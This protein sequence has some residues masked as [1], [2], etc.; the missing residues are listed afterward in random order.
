MAGVAVREK[1]HGIIVVTVGKFTPQAHYFANGLLVRLI[2]GT[3]LLRTLNKMN[4]GAVNP[5]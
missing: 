4:E 2:D 3:F 5:R 1:A